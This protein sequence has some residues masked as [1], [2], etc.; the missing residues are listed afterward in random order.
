MPFVL[1]GKQEKNKARGRA[2]RPG[3]LPLANIIVLSHLQ[4]NHLP[5]ICPEKSAKKTANTAC[6]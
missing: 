4:R 2:G 6:L 5:F 1:Q 3:K